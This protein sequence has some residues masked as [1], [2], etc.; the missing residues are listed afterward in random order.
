MLW[1]MSAMV[2]VFPVA[3]LA[4]NCQ[5][6]SKTRQSEDPSVRTLAATLFARFYHSAAFGMIGIK[7][8]YASEG[9]MTIVTSLGSW[10]VPPHRAA[11]IPA[12]I[13]TASKCRGAVSMRTLYILPRL[14]KALPKNAAP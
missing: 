10:V 6:M 3:G 8:L 13:V 9:V 1:A 11:W 5:V 12:N 7:L 4:L 14:S 2:A